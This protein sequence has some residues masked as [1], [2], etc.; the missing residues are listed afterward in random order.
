MIVICSFARALTNS[1]G[2]I[3]ATTASNYGTRICI[4]TN[5]TKKLWDFDILLQIYKNGLKSNG[6]Q[7]VSYDSQ[8]KGIYKM[9]RKIQI[10]NIKTIST[11]F[12]YDTAKF[13]DKHIL[14]TVVCIF[15]PEFELRPRYF[16]LHLMEN[17][18]VF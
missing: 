16:A 17:W 6:R 15:W 18:K 14:F 11:S 3:A 1:M 2:S 4:Y 9:A 12:G 8:P 7:T 10:Y 5:G 13:Y